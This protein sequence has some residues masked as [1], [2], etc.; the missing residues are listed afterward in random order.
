MVKRWIDSSI[1]GFSLDI[2]FNVVLLNLGVSHLTLLGCG[3]LLGRSL[4]GL[5]GGLRDVLCV[6]RSAAGLGWHGDAVFGR[7]AGVALSTG[8]WSV[9]CQASRSGD[10]LTR[11]PWTGGRAHRTPS[12]NPAE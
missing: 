1:I 7:K 5:L 10:G 8:T 9:I 2:L 12:A 3:G 11:H 4:L 6:R